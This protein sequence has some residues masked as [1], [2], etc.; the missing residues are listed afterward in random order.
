[1]LNPAFSVLSAS[2]F[3]VI[4]LGWN[5]VS[6][7]P[8]LA[9]I[10][11]NP[12]SVVGGASSTGTV[13]FTSGAPAG[14]AKVTLSTASSAI[15]VPAS[16]TIPQ[17]ADSAAFGIATSAVNVVTSATLTASYNGTAKTTTF[18]VMPTTPPPPPPPGV[19]PTLVNFALNPTTVVGGAS[20]TATITLS[21]PAPG[22]GVTVTVTSSNKTSVLVPSNVVVAAGSTSATFAVTTKAVGSKTLAKVSAAYAG[23]KKSVVITVTRR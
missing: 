13:T 2:D 16:V 18:T 10:G 5:P 17:G 22:G 4:Q 11:A 3:D 15:V 6:A 19:P 7:S 12:S 8:A 14:G 20:S 1:V 9:S 21:G 23:V